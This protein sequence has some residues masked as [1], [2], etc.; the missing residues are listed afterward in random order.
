[1][2]SLEMLDVAIGMIFVYLLISLICSAINEF[3]EAKLKLRAVDLEQGIRELLNDYDGT[4]L[5]KNIYDH[6]LIYSLFRGDYNPGPD[7]LPKTN[8]PA[9][10]DALLKLGKMRIN[11]DSQKNRYSRGSNL[12]SY[13]PAKNFALALMDIVFPSLKDTGTT[14]TSDNVLQLIQNDVS[15]IENANVKKA[16]S[17]IIITTGND[18]NKVREGIE[19]WY[20]ST[21]DRVSGWYKR[22]VQTILFYMGFAI[23]IIMNADSFAI[24]NNLI[25]DRPLRAAIV[26]VALDKKNSLQDTSANSIKKDV[27]SVLEL[28]LPIGYNWK[29]YL[30]QKAKTNLNAIPEFNGNNLGSSLGN[31]FLKV[32]GWL[33]TGFAVSLGAPFWFDILNRIMIIRSTVKP[34]EKSPEEGSQDWQNTKS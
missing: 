27:N 8:K 2:L 1:M 14:P 17:S 4:G 23:A 29:S 19:N 13:I 9:K 28:G 24:F 7:K 25:N 6:P 26:T 11:K 31:W 34:H 20:N 5:T 16:L 30:N 32:I 15:K 18:I 33:V 12:P 21:M 3:I 10:T 22:R